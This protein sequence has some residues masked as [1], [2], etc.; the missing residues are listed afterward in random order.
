MKKEMQMFSAT[1][2]GSDFQILKWSKDLLFAWNFLQPWINCEK[3]F[4]K[5]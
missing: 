5:A 1:T 4:L 2:V 3:S